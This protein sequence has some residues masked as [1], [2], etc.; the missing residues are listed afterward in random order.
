MQ[1][2]EDA[3]VAFDCPA[4]AAYKTPR[5][6][7]GCF[8]GTAESLQKG[9]GEHEATFRFV[10]NAFKGSERKAAISR[11]MYVGKADDG[12]SDE[13]RHTDNEKAEEVACASE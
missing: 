1:H 11:P 3:D 6:H 2:L 4:V 5:Q 9:R 12:Q 8:G 10:E 13:C 7:L